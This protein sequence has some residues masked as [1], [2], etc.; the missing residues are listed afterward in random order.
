MQGVEL[1]ERIEIHKLNTRLLVHLFCRHLLEETLRSTVGVA[2]A[3]AVRQT[4]Q[5]PVVAEVRNVATPRVDT[6]RY[7]VD[8]AC[9]R[10]LQ[11]AQHLVVE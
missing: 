2:V 3:I 10:L 5:L 6:D 11:T 7:G 9:C 1:E 4:E 8:A